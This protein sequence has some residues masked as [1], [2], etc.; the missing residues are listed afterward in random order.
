M[1]FLP[2]IGPVFTV[3]D[4]VIKRIAPE[5]MSELDKAK[6]AQDL[7]LELSKADFSQ[8]IEQIKVNVEEAKSASMFVAGWRPFVGWVC[9]IAMAYSFILQPFLAFLVGVYR[10]SLPPL[11]ALDAGS[12]MTVLLGMLGLGTMRTY[13]KIKG[14]GAGR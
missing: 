1:A 4:T 7:Q 6:L 11:P 10:W 14:V 3:I 8:A 5:K 9:G 2:F 13:E 12:L